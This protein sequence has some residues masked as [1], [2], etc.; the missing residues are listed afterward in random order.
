M[1]FMDF[2]RKAGAY[3]W[4]TIVVS[5]VFALLLGL[6][7]SFAYSASVY[8]RRQAEQM[9]QQLA[10]LQPGIKNSRS[11]QQIA[12]DFGGRESCFDEICR[13]DFGNRFTF[14]D[15]WPQRMLGRTEWDYFGLRPWIV[16]AVIRKANNEPT[17][18][19]LTVAVGWNRGFDMWSWKVV[20]VTMLSASGFEDRSTD[21]ERYSGTESER[22]TRLAQDRSYGVLLTRPN[23]DTP[24]GG[25]ALSVYL[26]SVAPSSSRRAAF[27]INLRCATSRVPCA[28]IFQLVPSLRPFYE[29]TLKYQ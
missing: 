26:S 24:G 14:S 7:W 8:R 4:H 18:V 9:L 13:Y 22:Q 28:E 3:I 27:D 29:R 12:K 11:A 23:L 6:Y 16:T 15:S 21:Q 19:Y 1:S 17:D 5:A 2:V 25:E 10:V 20:N